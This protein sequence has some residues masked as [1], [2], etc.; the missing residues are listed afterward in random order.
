MA[1]SP[2]TGLCADPARPIPLETDRLRPRRVLMTALAFAQSDLDG[3]SG[4]HPNT[5]AGVFF[6]V[7]VSR[8]LVLRQPGGGY[9]HQNIPRLY[10][11]VGAF[12]TRALVGHD[13]GLV[14]RLG[15]ETFTRLGLTVLGQYLDGPSAAAERSYR[16]GPA[17]QLEIMH[18]LLLRAALL[19]LG[20]EEGPRWLA[21]L[22][23]SAR[24]LDDVLLQ[25]R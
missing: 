5:A 16:V 3:W 8:S 4:F 19:P 21:G 2:K 24:L 7:G 22:E 17:V 11:H 20:T 13:A 6:Q 10:L 12:G 9:L 23:Y 25:P 1:I 15:S 14:Y 18:N